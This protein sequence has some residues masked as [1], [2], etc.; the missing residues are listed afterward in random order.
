VVQN[1]SREAVLAKFEAELKELIA[2]SSPRGSS[3]EAALPR[4]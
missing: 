1:R 2:S 3:Q 4:Q